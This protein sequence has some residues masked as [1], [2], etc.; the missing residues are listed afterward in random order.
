MPRFSKNMP[1]IN[2]YQKI[3]AIDPRVNNFYMKKASFHSFHEIGKHFMCYGQSYN[4]IPGHSGLIR[5]D[6][7]NQY[8]MKWKKYF[9]NNEKCA[10]KLNFFPNGYRLYVRKECL[11]FFKIINSENYQ[12]KK[13]ESPIQFIMKIGHGVHRGKGVFILD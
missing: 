1:K 3:F 11:A 8:S 6:L 9:V 12:E 2:W 7:L 13:N 5:K 10:K 4:H